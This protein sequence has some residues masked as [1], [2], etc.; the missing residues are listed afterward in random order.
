M[1]IIRFAAIGFLLVITSVTLAHQPTMSDGT[2]IGPDSAIELDDIQLSRVF[3]HEITQDAPSL[4]LTFDI[5]E[6]QSLYI[7]LGLPLLDRLEGFRPAFAV[8]G[9]GLSTIELPF[10]VPEGVGGVL[11]ETNDVMEP[12]V[13]HEP[14]SGTT[15]W[16]LREEDVDLPEA[17]TYYILAF[18]PSGET[19]KLWVAPGDREEFSLRDILA[20]TGV[21]ADV[22]DFHETTGGSF[23]CFLLPL[24]AVLAVFPALGL[25][26]LRTRNRVPGKRVPD[27]TST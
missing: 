7:S 14:F 21:L 11:F 5:A 1:K 24:A 20:L 8:L 6:P 16:I 15:S 17:G 4:W 22:R 25:L 9:P 12:E 19:G 27:G 26:G 2:A 23:P 10:D 13:F 18:V 3:Y